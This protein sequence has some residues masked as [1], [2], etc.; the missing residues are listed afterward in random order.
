MHQEIT[1]LSTEG[2]HRHEHVLL[3]ISLERSDAHAK[4]GLYAYILG[5][6]LPMSAHARLPEPCLH[7]ISLVL[8]RPSVPA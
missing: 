3:L 5:S 6:C 7:L 1:K 4:V 2:I 8:L